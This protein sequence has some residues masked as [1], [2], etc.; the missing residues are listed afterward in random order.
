MCCIVGCT[1]V[2]QIE[3]TPLA[4]DH[5]VKVT[6][7]SLFS[8]ARNLDSEGISM[9]L[10]FSGGGT[11]ASALSYGVMEELRNTT[12]FVKGEP[13]RLIDEIDIISAVS[14]GSFTAAYYGLFRDKLFVDYKRNMLT[15]NFSDQ[16][17]HTILNPFSW[18]SSLGRTDYAAEIYAEAGFGDATFSDMFDNGSPLIAINATDLSQGLRFTFLQDYFNLL[19]SDISDFPV[20][21]AVAASAAVPILFNPVVLEN[22]SNCEPTDLNN[23][24]LSRTHDGTVSLMNSAKAALSYSNKQKRPYVHLVDGGISDNLG[25]RMI[26]ESIEFAGGMKEFLD[27]AHQEENYLTSKDFV[28]IVVNASVKADS[29]IDTVATPPS[30]TQTINAVTD[31]QLHLYNSETLELAQTLLDDW[32]NEMSTPERPVKGHLV[33]VDLKSVEPISLNKKLN[34][35]P[36]T[37]G[38]PKDDVDLL[39]R[40]GRQM[41][42]SN[43]EYQNLLQSLHAQ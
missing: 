14:G 5:E 18:F 2:G 28:I 32:S 10:A 12:V 41:L 42:R 31:A 19:C 23:Y 13:I 25:L 1:T 20:S 30:L 38:L 11:R 40:I 3:N 15:R 26:I 37:L 21:R 43:V 9:V 24:L 33:V 6:Q 35:I 39:I 16:L 27:I 36:T 7:A 4:D 8:S 22:Y 29:D 34:L 17:F